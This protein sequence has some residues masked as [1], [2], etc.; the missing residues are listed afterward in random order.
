MYHKNNL[1]HINKLC[2]YSKWHTDTL[3]DIGEM[4]IIVRVAIYTVYFTCF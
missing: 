1:Y 3:P 2:G 4:H